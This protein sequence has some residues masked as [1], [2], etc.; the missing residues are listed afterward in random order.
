M[1]E[2]TAAVLR[3]T[4]KE[5]SIER[6]IAPELKQGQVRVKI[7]Y[8]GVCRS[9]LMEIS[10]GRGP[11]RWLPHLLGHEGSGE[12][13]E[14]S[15]GVNSVEPGDLVVISWIDSPGMEAES[16]SYTSMLDNSKI[17]S[18]PAV[19]FA[20]EVIVSEKKI[21]KKPVGISMEDAALLGCALPTGAGMV[22]NQAKPKKEDTVLI[23]GLGGIGL[24]ALIAAKAL[25]VRQI[26]AVDKDSQKLQIAKQLKADVLLNSNDANFMGK[27]QEAAP[28]GCDFC[29]EAGGTSETIQLGFSML[30][31]KKG[32]LYFASH[33]KTGEHITLDPH[34]LISGKKIFGS[35][36][37]GE[38]PSVTA[39][40]LDNLGVFGSGVLDILKGKTFRL[41]EINEAISFL[42]SAKITRPIISFI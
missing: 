4:G 35:W 24:S 30:N 19:T 31:S 38:Q 29:F 33:P 1:R 13:I 12:V 10:G 27:Y 23:I 34:H 36:G 32:V 28:N 8:S 11:D 21:F 9:Q 7:H 15:N 25:K 20:S 39:Q 40:K 18:G 3:E 2:I 16:A 5:L 37:G 41:E 42:K 17:N 14:V 6:L 26:I 22:L